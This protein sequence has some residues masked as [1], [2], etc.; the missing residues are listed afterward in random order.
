MP[1]SYSYNYKYH[2]MKMT[3]KL[4]IKYYVQNNFELSFGKNPSMKELV[5]LLSFYYFNCIAKIE[6]EIE[7]VH[8]DKIN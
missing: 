8:Y 1:I 3:S 2:I 7:S 4:G 6:N 5:K